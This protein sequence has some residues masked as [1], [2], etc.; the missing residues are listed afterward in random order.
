MS[1]PRT[2]TLVVKATNPE[3]SWLWDTLKTG[4]PINGV[5]VVAMADGWQI[6]DDS[7]EEE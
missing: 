2:L 6:K 1:E 5:K 3:A 7:D 4:Q